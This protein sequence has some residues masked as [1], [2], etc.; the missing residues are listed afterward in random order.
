MNRYRVL[1]VTVFFLFGLV[2][3]APALIGALPDRYVFR[4][5]ESLQKYGLP[6]DQSPLLPTVS[7]PAAAASLLSNAKEGVQMPTTR[8]TVEASPKVETSPISEESQVIEF[9]PATGAEP[10]RPNETT[11]QASDDIPSS[12]STTTPTSKSTATL[13]ATAMQTATPWPL[14]KQAR[15]EGFQHNFQTW[16]NCGPATLAMGLTFFGEPVSQEQTASVLKPDPEDRNVSP[17]EM[18]S[19]VNEHTPHDA[20]F[21]SNGTIETL[22]KLVANDVP[23]IIETGIDPPGEFRWLGWYGHY[24]LVVAYSDEEEQF[25]V[26]D[27]WFKLPRVDYF[28]VI[29]ILVIVA[30]FGYLEGVAAGIGIALVIFVF[31]CTLST[32]TG[33]ARGGVN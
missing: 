25:W 6:Q 17:D 8:A 3:A 7:A 21:R 16:N 22:K 2:L 10:D 31:N 32:G 30:M 33:I 24:L 20:L 18:A 28:L 1:L 12:T 4:L 15:L 5:P 19:Y 14:P 9:K 27:S 13:V 26:Y 29:L 11:N 23:V